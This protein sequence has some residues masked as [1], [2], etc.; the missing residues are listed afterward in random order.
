M[1]LLFKCQY[2]TVSSLLWCRK[3]NI[4]TEIKLSGV[5]LWQSDSEILSNSIQIYIKWIWHRNSSEHLK[6]RKISADARIRSIIFLNYSDF[7]LYKLCLSKDWKTFYIY[8][9]DGMWFSFFKNVFQCRPKFDPETSK[10]VPFNIWLVCLKQLW[11]FS[12][13]IT[14]CFIQ[15]GRVV[16]D[17]WFFLSVSW[18]WNPEKHEVF[19]KQELKNGVQFSKTKIHVFAQMDWNYLKKIKLRESEN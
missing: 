11:A 8:I 5:K 9:W 10:S 14:F 1:K 3:S 6:Y 13:H 12:L 19:K 15:I 4:W 7:K 17:I 16:L 18:F 2:Y